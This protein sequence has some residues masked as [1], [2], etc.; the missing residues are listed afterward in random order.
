MLRHPDNRNLHFHYDEAMHRHAEKGRY[1]SGGQFP[2]GYLV[3]L[4]DFLTLSWGDAGCSWLSLMGH[5]FE[6]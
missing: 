4:L 5:S 1:V 6:A 3:D 2:F